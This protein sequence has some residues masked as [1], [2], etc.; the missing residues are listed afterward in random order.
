MGVG[1]A[2]KVYV[3]RG[4]GVIVSAIA[5]VGVGVDGKEG[6]EDWHATTKTI[7][8]SEARRRAAVWINRQVRCFMLQL[9]QEEM[10]EEKLPTL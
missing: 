1:D 3:G 6:G 4:D 2:V 5:C 8:T 9:Y 7:K 10:M